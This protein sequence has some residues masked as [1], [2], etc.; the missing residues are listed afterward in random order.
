ME[1]LDSRLSVNYQAERGSGSVP[2]VTLIGA[3]ARL[4]KRKAAQALPDVPVKDAGKN[5]DRDSSCQC[6]QG[7]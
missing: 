2:F 1:H 7:S 4:R 3:L 5:F 6:D